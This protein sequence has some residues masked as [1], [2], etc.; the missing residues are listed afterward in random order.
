MVK[1]GAVSRAC[2]FME[3]GSA[4]AH[5]SLEPDMRCVLLALNARQCSCTE[6]C[7]HAVH[8]HRKWTRLLTGSIAR[9]LQ[10]RQAL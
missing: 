10:N 4:L 2:D 1:L 3:G 5:S 9:L 7:M 6:L 8:A